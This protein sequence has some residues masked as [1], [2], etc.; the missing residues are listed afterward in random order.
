MMLGLDLGRG[1]DLKATLFGLGLETQGPDLAV[2][3]LGLSLSLAP[4]GLVNT[5]SLEY[6]LPRPHHR[7]VCILMKLWML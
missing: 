7:I 5:T 2:P 4:C 1:L 3:C 6:R